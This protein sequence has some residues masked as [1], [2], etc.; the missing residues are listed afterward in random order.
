MDESIQK[1]PAPNISSRDDIRRREKV[2]F[3]PPVDKPVDQ[4]LRSGSLDDVLRSP[5]KADH[6]KEES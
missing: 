6:D 1:Q 2:G 5:K 3:V 4:V